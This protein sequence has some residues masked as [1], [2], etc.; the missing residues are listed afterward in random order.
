MRANAIAP[1]L[2]ET[3]ITTTTTKN[4]AFGAK[5]KAV[6]E[7]EIPLGRLGQPDDFGPLVIDICNSR[8]MTGQVIVVDGGKSLVK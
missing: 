7:K 3:R 2:I 1:A 4:S 5:T 8:Y 6:F